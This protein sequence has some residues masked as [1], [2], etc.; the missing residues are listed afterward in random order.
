MPRA[1]VVTSGKGGVGKTTITSNLGISLATKGQSVVLVDLDVGLNNLDLALGIESNII[2]DLA[3]CL[4]GKCRLGQALVAH[5]KCPNL[6]VLACNN[7]ESKIVLENNIGRV[8]EKLKEQFDWVLIDSPAGIDSGFL[9]ATQCADEA[10]VVVTPHISSVRDSDKVISILH[11]KKINK[12]GV[13]VNRIRGDLVAS[14]LMIGVGQI[15]TAL[16]EKIVGIIPDSDILCTNGTYIEKNSDN[17]R[18]AF[19][20][21]ARNLINDDSKEFDYLSRYKGIFGSVRRVLRRKI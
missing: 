17:D 4:S 8:I 9:C 1:I 6:F 13:V 3:D 2:F 5:P 19:S 16:K 18:L 7:A 15:S 20:I 21:L 12:I 14:G 10:L 11:S